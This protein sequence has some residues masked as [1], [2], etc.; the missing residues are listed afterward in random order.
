[1]YKRM[2]TPTDG[3]IVYIDDDDDD[4]FLFEQTLKTLGLTNEV[5]PFFDGREALHYLENTLER[6]LL[7]LCDL[8]MPIM[9]GLE[10]RQ[11]IDE[12]EYL[13]QKSIPFVFYT[14]AAGPEQ[15]RKAYEGTI[16]GFHAKA[17]DLAEYRAQINL[18]VNYWKSCLH[19]NSF[20]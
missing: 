15:V 18:I 11:N 5:R 3:P 7:I 4:H 10:L 12:N 14:T 6:P 13:K 17:Q 8:N 2:I 1:M 19:P 16:Q 9:N 20:D